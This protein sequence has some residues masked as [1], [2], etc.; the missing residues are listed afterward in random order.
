MKRIITLLSIIAILFA[1]I[2][3]AFAEE[4]KVTVESTVA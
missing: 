3:P 1:N 2:E 4:E